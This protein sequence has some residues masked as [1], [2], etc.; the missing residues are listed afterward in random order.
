MTRVGQPSDTAKDKKYVRK[1]K[2]G[3]P[4]EWIDM[5]RVLEEIWI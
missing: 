3:N 1:L 5:L 4:K 2:E